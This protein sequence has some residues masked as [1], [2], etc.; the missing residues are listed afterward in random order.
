[1][2]FYPEWVVLLDDTAKSDK[3]AELTPRIAQQI[4]DAIK[5]LQRERDNLQAEL[6]GAPRPPAAAHDCDIPP[7]LTDSETR[8]HE[9]PTC[10]AHW[11]KVKRMVGRT[12]YRSWH[13]MSDEQARRLKAERQN[14][15]P[16]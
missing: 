15:R 2:D 16:A 12:M 8:Y 10:G 9:C 3:P 13:R 6:D 5:E 7:G 11:V 1:M 4:I 14:V